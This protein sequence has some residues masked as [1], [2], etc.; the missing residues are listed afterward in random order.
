MI[1]GPLLF[2][3]YIEVLFQFEHPSPRDDL[4]VFRKGGHAINIQIVGKP[5]KVLP[6]NTL[7]KSRGLI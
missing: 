7:M 6:S 2:G 4:Y 3:R 1:M 5:T